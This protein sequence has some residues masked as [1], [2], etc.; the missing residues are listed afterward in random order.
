MYIVYIAFILH[1]VKARAGQN[2]HMFFLKPKKKP[3]V[4]F[5][6]SFSPRSIAVSLQRCL[7]TPYSNRCGLWFTLIYRN[8]ESLAVIR[9]LSEEDLH[10]YL[11][12]T[13]RRPQLP[14][15]W[16][17]YITFSVVCQEVLH[18]FFERSYAVHSRT[19]LTPKGRTRRRSVLPLS[20]W[21]Y[22]CNI[23]D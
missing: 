2:E 5:V 7:P 15:P 1:R 9:T 6:L 11:C 10:G 18:I 12:L 23:L 16:F 8:D 21:H 4:P 13:P 14:L 3:W 17:N 19:F 20:S 22:Y